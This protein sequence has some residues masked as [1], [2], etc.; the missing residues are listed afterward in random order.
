MPAAAETSATGWPA[1]TTGDG[2]SHEANSFHHERDGQNVAFADQHVDF[3][4]TAAEGGDNIYA[5]GNRHPSTS[6][7]KQKAAAACDPKL[8]MRYRFQCLHGICAGKPR[9]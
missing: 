7:L 3:L 4:R 2:A 9:A 5:E 8:A 6:E 1:A